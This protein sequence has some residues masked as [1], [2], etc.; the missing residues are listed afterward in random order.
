MIKG[1]SVYANSRGLRRQARQG[2]LALLLTALA[3][4]SL[5]ACGDGAGAPT[6]STRPPGMTPANTPA[7]ASTDTPGLIPAL[8]G[9]SASGGQAVLY[10]ELSS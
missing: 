9:G 7:P 1:W 10:C 2:A 4:A 5:A 8:G 3:A 6:Q